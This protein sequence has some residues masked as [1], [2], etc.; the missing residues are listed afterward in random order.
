MSSE[1]DLSKWLSSLKLSEY[2][3]V[4]QRSNLSRH[5]VV[6]LSHEEL[7]R[8][9]IDKLGHRKRLLKYK[10]NFGTDVKP[11]LSRHPTQESQF[12]NT[13]S[14]TNESFT[15]PPQEA[16]PQRPNPRKNF[17]PPPSNL[18]PSMQP[19]SNGDTPPQRPPPRSANNNPSLNTSNNNDAQLPPKPPRDMKPTLGDDGVVRRIKVTEGGSIRKKT[20]QDGHTEKFRQ[21]ALLRDVAPLPPPHND[22]STDTPL[23]NQTNAD[24]EDIPPPTLPKKTSVRR[25][26][27]GSVYSVP[28]SSQHPTKPPP[29]P[30]SLPSSSNTIQ[31]STYDTAPTSNSSST[32]NSRFSIYSTS[33][34]LLEVST[35]GDS[36]LMNDPPNGDSEDDGA[37][38]QLPRGYSNASRIRAVSSVSKQVPEDAPPP[39][40]TKAKIPEP[41]KSTKGNETT[42]TSHSVESSSSLPVYQV[43]K[44]P[45]LSPSVEKSGYLDKKGG[46]FGQ[47]GWDRRF[48]VYKD[49]VLCYYTNE[50][51]PTPQGSIALSD[52]KGVTF[53]STK[54]AKKHTNRFTLQTYQRTYYFSADTSQ[55]MTEWLTLL[56]TQIELHKPEPTFGGKMSN[57]DLEGWLRVKSGGSGWNRRYVVL[58]GPDFHIYQNFDAFKSEKPSVILQAV[59]LKV[60]IGGTGKK[61]KNHQFQIVSAME[62]YEFQ[63]STKEEMEDWTSSV[64]NAIA[65]AFNE[66]HSTNTN[67]RKDATKVPKE[68]VNR[69]MA[70][71]VSN[72]YC[73]D[74]GSPNPEWISINL[75]ATVC[76]DCSGSHRGLGTHI[77]K[78][79]SYK[80]DDMEP[81]SLDLVCAIGSS[82]SN[83]IWE[84]KL[85]E[86]GVSKINNLS[87]LDER[88]AYINK[89][90]ADR[91]FFQYSIDVTGVDVS[92]KLFDVVATDDVFSALQ[93]I[94]AG[95]SATYTHENGWSI[96]RNAYHHKQ[97]TQ[98]ELLSRN[99]FKLSEQEKEE[100]DAAMHM[101]DEDPAVTASVQKP[102]IS[103]HQG[104][105]Q[106]QS[107]DLDWL[108]HFAVFDRVLLTLHANE[109]PS[110]PV[111]RQIPLEVMKSCSRN[112]DEAK[113]GNSRA[114]VIA[115]VSGKVHRFAAEDEARC[116]QWV[117]ILQPNIEAIPDDEKG[118]DFDGCTLSGQLERRKEGGV[119]E[120]QFYG[121]AGRTLIAFESM[122]DPTRI[123]EI[124]LRNVL[125]FED[126]VAQFV[127]QQ[128]T[129]SKQHG[130]PYTIAPSECEFSLILRQKAY[131]FRAADS[132][133][134]LMWL[135]ALNSTR[136]FG[137][138]LDQF[139][140]LVPSIV[141]KCCSFIESFG[142]LTE[143]VY[144]VAG[145]TSDI[146]ALRRQFDM[147]EDS[148]KLESE[149]HDV[150]VVSS[151]L[152]LFFKELPTPL[153]NPTIKPYF[154]SILP[155]Q[156][157]DKKIEAMVDL[158]T[159]IS[160]SEYE[161]TKRMCLHFKAISAHSS[162]NKMTPT[163][164]ALVFGPTFCFGK[165]DGDTAALAETNNALKLVE[166]FIKHCEDLFGME[167]K[168]SQEQLIED[169]ISRIEA[170]TNMH[171]NAEN[172]KASKFLYTI[173]FDDDDTEISVPLAVQ[174]TSQEVVNNILQMKGVE[175]SVDKKWSLFETYSDGSLTRA[176]A[177]DETVLSAAERQIESN[178]ALRV[179]PNN[180]FGL[181]E[182]SRTELS[183][184]LHYRPPANKLKK[185]AARVSFG[186]KT[187]WKRVFCKVNPLEGSRPSLRIYKNED[188]ASTVAVIE[189]GKD[190]RVYKAKAKNL[191]PTQ[192]AFVI[193]GTNKGY[194]QEEWFCA[195]SESNA[196]KWIATLASAVEKA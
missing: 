175:Q 184:Y 153:I 128:S 34:D 121:L 14:A 100:E 2:Y 103:H 120:S 75:G 97:T 149:T 30:P 21:S 169:G 25:P 83:T 89:K 93:Y 138:A 191:D 62:S 49:G 134:K 60:K 11:V 167:S 46:Q 143:G 108:E 12:S 125:K 36:M 188:M 171:K 156:E 132:A 165:N 87:S 70:E 112:E 190:K 24:A 109:D 90:Y 44:S 7:E 47:K 31:A 166:F 145:T 139:D 160:Y 129:K 195:E 43:D 53:T 137:V 74:C 163:N 154:Y 106:A 146:T 155:I 194:V 88:K 176:L 144:R 5:S 101:T 64:N 57:P 65:E 42:Q 98:V 150:H 186:K 185:M 130:I 29:L 66:V 35:V 126:G 17:A 86:S 119:Y 4:F 33:M 131:R 151:V 19:S 68:E 168:T 48:F 192:F 40:P 127:R 102:L 140:T 189:L 26:V 158:F 52:M 116:I 136:V 117:E 67:S 72:K 124:D 61:A 71:S 177:E 135:E 113:G 16:A 73:A 28:K 45:L 3:D 180:F 99:D 85:N 69:R 55:A 94:L 123:N 182:S 80:L 104:L 179:S 37:Y 58:K 173:F 95:A 8:M 110:S 107:D 118:F 13:S 187:S 162:V 79:R 170:A 193:Q 81:A 41:Y 63:A 54:G 84:A 196:T 56:G 147:D 133:A 91:A 111:I 32:A 6:S 105:V 142:I 20:M 96:A 10:D 181:I 38:F 122:T 161:T 39:R 23:T 51:D 141:E 76:I 148:V 92:Q 178:V 22:D 9:G 59:L 115:T 174:T 157:E 152:K 159:R 164:L 27:T 18:P 50:K 78:M 172:L 114:F 15:M 183:G 82:K 77:S 1:D